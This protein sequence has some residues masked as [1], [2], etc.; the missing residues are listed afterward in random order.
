MTTYT[1]TVL[2]VRTKI[3]VVTDKIRSVETQMYASELAII[4]ITATNDNNQAAID[5][6]NDNIT[7]MQGK[8]EALKSELTKLEAQLAKET[9]Q[10]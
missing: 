2:D 9:A 6:A 4:E 10:A 1:Y 8:A 5:A 7:L 3:N